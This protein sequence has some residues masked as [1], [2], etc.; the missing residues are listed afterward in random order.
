MTRQNTA[1]DKELSRRP[2]APLRRPLHRPPAQPP[3]LTAPDGQQGGQRLHLP[4]QALRRRSSTLPRRRP[5][6]SAL[7]SHPPHRQLTLE[8]FSLASLP[9]CLH[10]QGSIFKPLPATQPRAAVHRTTPS[11][12]LAA[13]KKLGGALWAPY[14]RGACTS[15]A[16][17]TRHH[18]TPPE[19][20]SLHNI[21]SSISCVYSN[22]NVHMYTLNK[23]S[24]L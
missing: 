5:S 22:H 19:P 20:V 16:R 17:D 13:T 3:P 9:G 8:P 23:V 1:A 21:S 4:A 7:T 10:A 15:K 14:D 11:T 12:L 6:A 24:T 18:S 2:R